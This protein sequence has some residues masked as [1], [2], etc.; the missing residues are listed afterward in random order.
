MANNT[1]GRTTKPKQGTKGTK[2]KTNTTKTSKAPVKDIAAKPEAVEPIED[3]D[4][5]IVKSPGKGNKKAYL[6]SPISK[7]NA[8]AMLPGDNSKY[9]AV[10]ME[11]ASWPKPNKTDMNALE[12]RFMEY[13]QYCQAH[14]VK[15][16]NQMA[17]LAMGL[18][19]DDVYDMEHGRKLG[20]TASDFIK[21]V[22]QICAGNREL[23]MQDGKVNPIAG[24]FW[25][26][27]YDSMKDVQDITITANTQLQ[28]T[29][30]MEEIA[31]KVAKDVVI[32]IDYSE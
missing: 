1:T 13:M 14:D 23:L 11:F 15:I 12:G 31:D 27:N 5:G 26:K 30:S 6:N 4:T 19:K 21:K 20:S 17:Y 10:L 2:A 24:I 25:Q 29:M 32:D 7:V 3:K 22:K 28:P 16:G 18:N 8:P 9:A